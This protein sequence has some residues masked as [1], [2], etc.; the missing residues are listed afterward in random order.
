MVSNT[1]WLTNADTQP[2]EHMNVQHAASDWHHELPK[3][4]SNTEI[5][6]T[7]PIF[8]PS[9]YVPDPNNGISSATP[10]YQP[11]ENPENNWAGYFP[12][13]SGHWSEPQSINYLSENFPSTS[14]HGDIPCKRT[15]WF[16][17]RTVM[18]V[19]ISV[20]KD[21]AARRTASLVQEGY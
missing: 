3:S 8:S 2:G 19:G 13:S 14:F 16:K 12:A 21:V 5:L 18:K 17:V 11:E 20:R 4:P 1:G 9:P 15:K 6:A 7:L 10:L